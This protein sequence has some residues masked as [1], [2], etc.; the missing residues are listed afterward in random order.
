MPIFTVQPTKRPIPPGFP[1]ARTFPHFLDH[2]DMADAVYGRVFLSQFEMDLIDTPE[3]Q[4]LFR[5]TQLGFVDLLYHTANHRR[6]SHSIGACGISKTLIAKLND[7]SA[8]I[9]PSKYPGQSPPY[10]SL[11]S[12]VLISAGA[13]LHDLPH[14]PFSHD[15]EKKTHRLTNNYLSTDT[16]AEERILSYSGPYNKHDDWRTNPALYL[17]LCDQTNSVLARVLAAYSPSFW[18][19][20]SSE[21]E[22]NPDAAWELAPLIDALDGLDPSFNEEWTDHILPQLLLHLLVGER[23]KDFNDRGQ[24][25]LARFWNDTLPP[26]PWSLGSD[27]APD[28]GDSLHFAWYQPYRHDII[29]DTLSA[30]LL[31]YLQ[32]DSHGLALPCA[33]DDRYLDHLLLVPTGPTSVRPSY[34]CAL[35][36]WDYKRG[37]FHPEVPEDLFRMLDTRFAI[38]QKAIF[39]RVVQAAVAML[40]RAMRLLPAHMKPPPN[41]LY[42]W[43]LST[44][45]NCGSERALRGDDYLLSRLIKTAAAADAD[46][47]SFGIAQKLAERRLYK[48]LIMM[49]GDSIH[50]LLG[51]SPGQIEAIIRELAALLDSEFYDGFFREIERSIEALL[52]HSVSRQEITQRFDELTRAESALIELQDR[53]ASKRVIFWAL[54]YKQLY[55]DPSIRISL[56]DA[57]PLPIEEF[58]ARAQAPEPRKAMQGASIGPSDLLSLLEAG[59]ADSEAK[60]RASWNASVFLSDG[61][62]YKGLL[63]RYDSG[64]C[65]EHIDCLKESCYLAVGALRAA[66]RDWVDHRENRITWLKDP[67]RLHPLKRRPEP[68]EFRRLLERLLDEDLM[69]HAREAVECSGHGVG[70]AHYAHEEPAIGAVLEFPEQCRDI[71]YKFDVRLTGGDLDVE[72]GRLLKNTNLDEEIQGYVEQTLIGVPDRRMTFLEAEELVSRFVECDALWG[73]ELR[74][75]VRGQVVE[76]GI[77]RRGQGAEVLARLRWVLRK[78]SGV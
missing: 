25:T 1:Q 75:V 50:G 47:P 41:E 51:E 27:I 49:P 35:D 15:V 16:Q 33:L 59:I 58:V 42:A 12:S 9:W 36:F 30:D 10:V 74:T 5:L 21:A 56:R 46:H 26:E 60:Y 29:G 52:T 67:G 76:T 32:R 57:S 64:L 18:R 20:L 68:S 61:L 69:T 62:F 77:S 39:H 72:V 54:P 24:I 71:R 48:P 14:S 31:D 37:T 13:L 70:F 66:W 8:R 34:G 63:A 2:R 28:I 44:S 38:H 55:K 78:T 6:G 7:N 73:D 45:D 65:R 11:S 53:P 3:F 19:L 4:R 43:P 17:M 40:W 22:N 23:P